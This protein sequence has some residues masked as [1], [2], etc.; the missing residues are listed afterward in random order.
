MGPQ[1]GWEREGGR[2]REGN[3]GDGIE[4]KGEKGEGRGPHGQWPTRPFTLNPPLV[5]G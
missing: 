3:G 4:R 5:K 1:E 2:R